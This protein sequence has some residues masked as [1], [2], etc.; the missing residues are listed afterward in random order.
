MRGG[1]ARHGHSP[2]G[3]RSSTYNAW[4]NMKARC[5]DKNNPH[6][7]GKGISYDPRWEVFDNFL[8]DMGPKPDGLTLERIDNSLGYQPGNC[9]WATWDEQNKNRANSSP[10]PGVYWLPVR[11]KWRAR[12]FV[13][14]IP[15]QIGNFISFDEAK[16]A[17]AEWK[18]Q[19]AI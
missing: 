4:S 12:G 10:T 3:R 15:V 19:N 9:K 1:I 11:K 7:G 2:E 18:R 6:Y 16:E 13:K 17:V 8:C 14:G 5:H